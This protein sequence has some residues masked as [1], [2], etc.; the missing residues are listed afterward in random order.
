MIVGFSG[1]V[2][3]GVIVGA[4]PGVP[5]AAQP[6]IAKK[7]RAITPHRRHTFNNGQPSIF[8]ESP[9][10]STNLRYGPAQMMDSHRQTVKPTGPTDE[11]TGP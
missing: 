4:G 7:N 2:S 5:A 1:A 6:A 10:I 8:T 9:P 11:E 3:A